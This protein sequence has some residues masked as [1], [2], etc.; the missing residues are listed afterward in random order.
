METLLAIY[1]TTVLIWFLLVLTAPL[2]EEVSLAAVIICF[3]PAYNSVLLLVQLP[4]ILKWLD[5]RTAL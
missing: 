5:K 3:L 1:L 4:L 2:E